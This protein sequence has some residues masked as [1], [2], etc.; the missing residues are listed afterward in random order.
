MCGYSTNV[1]DTKA[2]GCHKSRYCS[3]LLPQLFIAPE[4]SSMLLLTQ[5]LLPVVLTAL[6]A[7]L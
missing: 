1:Y 3:I 2:V 7:D 5:V 4:L 6:T